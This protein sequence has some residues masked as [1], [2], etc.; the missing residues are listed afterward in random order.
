MATFR[1]TAERLT[2]HPHGNADALELAQVG[3][4]RAVVAKGRFTTGDWA[5]YIP[6]GA[7]LPDALI[8]ELGL[9]G[10]L[11]GSAGNRVKAVRLRG[12]LSQ[13]IVCL[14]KGLRRDP[15]TAGDHDFGPELGIVK[16][17]PPI[18][19]HMSGSVESAPELIRWIEIE[20]VKRFPAM[21]TPGE[22]VVASEK[23]HGSATLYTFSPD[24]DQVSSKG[25]GSRDQ[26]L[27]RDPKNLYWRAVLGHEVPE[28]ARAVAGRFGAE[29]VGV[30]GEVF[31]K[32]VQ[33]LSY[34]RSGTEELPG[35]AVFDIAVVVGGVK[36]WLD[37]AEVGD[38]TAE[39]GLPAVPVLYRGPY[40]EE[41]LFGLASG[42]ETLSG[43]GAH[44]REGLVV[45]PARERHS[46]LTG[47]RAIAKFVSP[48]YL[49]RKGG[50]EYE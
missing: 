48:A 40:D 6:E 31:G 9:V 39:L 14:P 18:P 13:G 19:V 20:D 38:V 43:T 7:L 34:G 15:A 46:D 1:V 29:R 42:R 16:W 5:L 23:L 26:A 10:R 8:E 27:V 47:G 28:R 45:R 25:F 36:R 35:Y 12:E 32:G 24:G 11:A 50:T 41:V 3:L 33:D 21:F 30:F 4:Y 37:P 44:L 49:T 22:P 17:I 2:I